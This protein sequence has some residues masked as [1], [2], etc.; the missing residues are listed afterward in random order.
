MQTILT[1]NNNILT[2]ISAQY[3]NVTWN[4]EYFSSGILQGGVDPSISDGARDSALI[5][6]E[7]SASAFS[8]NSIKSGENITDREINILID[9]IYNETSIIGGAP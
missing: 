4:S 9:K 3:P 6:K 7:N 5:N 1:Y 2:W 8:N